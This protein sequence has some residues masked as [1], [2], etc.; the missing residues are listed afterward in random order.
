[1]E[2][3]DRRKKW[4]D[5]IESDII[6]ISGVSVQEMRDRSLWRRRTNVTDPV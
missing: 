1:M 3:E 4:T 2:G 6:I 5:G